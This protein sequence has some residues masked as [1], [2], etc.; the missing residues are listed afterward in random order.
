[1]VPGPALRGNSSEYGELA[2][3][4]VNRVKERKTIG[5]EVGLQGGFVHQHLSVLRYE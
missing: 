1:M 5:I 4:D 2:L 3:H